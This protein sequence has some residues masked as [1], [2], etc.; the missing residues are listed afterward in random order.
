MIVHPR[1]SRDLLANDVALLV[2]SKPITNVPRVQ[3]AAP[4]QQLAPGEWLLASGFGATPT[5][6]R[7]AALEY[8][9]V[10]FL[11]RRSCQ[12]RTLAALGAIPPSHLC[13]GGLASG[14]DTCPGDS[15]GPLV[16]DRAAR[17]LQVRCV[18]VCGR[19]GT[20]SA[21]R[22][23]RPHSPPPPPPPHTPPHTLR[24]ALSRTAPTQSAA[25]VAA[26]GSTRAW[27]PCAPGSTPSSSASSWAPT[28]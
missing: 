1:Y 10:P 14:A 3:L 13:A 16:V 5:T 2:L 7:S 24:W 15:G 4:R 6:Y 26:S 20:S 28:D 27:Q 21:W 23:E 11:P 22:R 8:T 9:F 12:A 25:G 17:D 18:C 19:G